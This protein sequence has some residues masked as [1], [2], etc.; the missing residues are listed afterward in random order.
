MGRLYT[1]D[2][3]EW[4]FT[5]TQLAGNVM[6]Y[7]P[8]LLKAIL[9]LARIFAARIQSWA[10]KNALWTDRTSNARQGLFARAIPL[11]TGVAIVLFH[12]VEY[13]IW[14]EIANAGKYAIIMWALRAHYGALMAALR[15]LVKE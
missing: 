9:A 7:G 4:E 1:S 12:T 6:G 13:G 5:P 3:L 10:R 14:L 8:R 11:A 15:G 2:R